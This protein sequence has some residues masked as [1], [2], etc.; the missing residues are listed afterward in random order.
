[1]RLLP[2]IMTTW[3]L[4]AASLARGKAITG[5]ASASPI[6]PAPGA[7]PMSIVEVA[8]S[9]PDLVVFATLLKSAGLAGVLSG[10][11]PF[12]VFAPTNAAFGTFDLNSLL[13]PANFKN[14]RK[15]LGYHVV[16]GA[17]NFTNGLQVDTLEGT[18]LQVAVRGGQPWQL[19][20][21]Y[22]GPPHANPRKS[23]RRL[24]K[25][26]GVW[27]RI[28]AP[29]QRVKRGGVHHRGGVSATQHDDSSGSYAP[30]QL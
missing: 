22:V 21:T 18:P 10:P 25:H 28:R 1:M 8:N 26:Q 15:I 24:S 5:G 12:A 13:G 17:F 30:G 27:L 11:G 19:V 23:T 9:N 16:E 6:A 20:G 14:L 4:C 29:V 2:L 7:G 3:A